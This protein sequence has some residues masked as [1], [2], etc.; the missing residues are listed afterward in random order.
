MSEL[1]IELADVPTAVTRGEFVVPTVRVSNSGAETVP[2]SARLNLFE[3]DLTVWLTDPH[4]KQTPLRGVFLIDSLLRQVELAP[5]HRLE[6]GIFLS[7]TSADDPFQTT[8]VYHLEAEYTPRITDPPIT[9]DPVQFQVVEPTTTELRELATVTTTELKRAVALAG[10]DTPVPPIRDQLRVL[11]T[12]YPHRAEG[13]IAG[14]ALYQFADDGEQTKE[15]FESSVATHDLLTVARLISALIGTHTAESPLLTGF[16][17][18]LDEMAD[19]QH[20]DDV[21]RIVRGEPIPE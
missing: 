3:G 4:G 1:I 6:A 11:A 10:F 15:I 19:R 2:I 8:G 17:E 16:L 9:S 13:A 5:G 7:Y 14:L 18:S 20:T 12:R 21:R